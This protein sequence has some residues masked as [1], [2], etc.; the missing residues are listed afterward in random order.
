MP[1]H[2]LVRESYKRRHLENK[3]KRIM[4]MWIAFFTIFSHAWVVFYLEKNKLSWRLTLKRHRGQFD[5][6]CGFSKN[7]GGEPLIFII[8]HMTYYHILSHNIKSYLITEKFIEV[9][10]VVWKIKR[11]PQSI[12]TI[13]INFLDFWHFLVL[14]KLMA[15]A[16]NI[17]CLQF[18]FFDLP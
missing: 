14:K 15:S 10:Q 12:L 16:H 11:F 8:S 6:R 1:A 5:A 3:A 7:E 17:W 4:V 18:F 13:F 2:T 9:P